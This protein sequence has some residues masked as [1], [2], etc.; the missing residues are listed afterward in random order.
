MVSGKLE[1]GQTV[2]ATKDNILGLRYRDNEQQDIFFL[3]TIHKRPQL[4]AT[5]RKSKETQNDI[6]TDYHSNMGYNHKNDQVF[7]TLHPTVHKSTKWTTKI[8]FYLLEES[9]RNAHVIYRASPRQPSLDFSDFKL[10][11]VK[12]I[13]QSSGVDVMQRPSQGHHY[14][15]R[16]PAT[17]KNKFPVKRCV[18]CHKNSVTRTS[19]YFCP[20]CVRKPGLCVDPC[21]RIHHNKN[22]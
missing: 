4:V 19:R 1:R 20:D 5:G 12:E 15:Q 7:A 13:L 14:P 8:F 6:V 11:Y 16:L 10:A 2:Y 21:F 22:L 3:S 9:F 17:D 18:E